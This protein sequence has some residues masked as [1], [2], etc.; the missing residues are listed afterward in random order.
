MVRHVVVPLILPGLASPFGV[1]LIQASIA[2]V[3]VSR[4]CVWLA[5][6]AFGPPPLLNP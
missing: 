6:F 1:F 5:V 2:V 3:I 4:R